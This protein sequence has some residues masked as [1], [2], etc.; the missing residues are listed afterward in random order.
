MRLTKRNYFS[1]KAQMEYMSV[2]QFKDFKACEEMALA[3]I[4]GQYEPVRGTALY[5]GSYIDA[6]FEGTL[7]KFKAENPEIF[8]KSGDLKSE[9]KKANEIITRIERDELFMQLLSG[10]KQVIKTGEICGVP[11]KIKMDSYIPGRFIVDLKIVKDFEPLYKKD[12]GRLNFIEYWGYD[13]QGAAYQ[14]IEGNGLPF[15]I[16][17]ATKE[18]VTDIDAFEIPQAYLDVALDEIKENIVRYQSIKMGLITPDRC[19]KCDWCKMTKKL[20][21]IR[22]MEELDYE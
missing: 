11:F 5:V 10:R 19:G 9:Y 7:D 1:C 3:K 20:E 12:E 15:V 17:A 2:S 16:A 4:N 14:H 13:L 6:H 21:H 22:A 8:T 18:P